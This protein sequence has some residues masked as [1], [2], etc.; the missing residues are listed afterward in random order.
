MKIEFV[1]RNYIP[2][3]RQY[4]SYMSTRPDEFEMVF[5]VVKSNLKRF[6]GIYR[7]FGGLPAV[8]PVVSLAQKVFFKE[9]ARSDADVFFYVGMLPSKAPDRP[10]VIDIEHIYSLMNFSSA[11]EEQKEVILRCIQNSFCKGVVPWS[12]AARLGMERFLGGDY[13]TV[14]DKVKVLYPAIPSLPLQSQ[15]DPR[16]PLQERVSVSPRFRF[17][18]IGKDANRKGLRQLLEA[19]DRLFLKNKDIVLNVVT[20]CPRDLQEKY[21]GHKAVNFYKPKFSPDKIMSEFFQKSDV[22]VMPTMADTFGL[23]FLEA[24]ASGLPVITT[25]QFANP[26]IVEQGRDG[27]LLKHEPLFLDTDLLPTSRLDEE[28]IL[29]PQRN[30]DLVEQLL[31]IMEQ[32]TSHPEQAREMGESASKKF[33][34]E[35]RFS[36]KKRDDLLAKILL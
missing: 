4:F 26:E 15:R 10:F 34:D 20:E 13:A 24:M 27:W 30:A 31:V 35:G 11:K 16:E 7:R 29:P 36:V 25:S 33:L 8:R 1:Y 32:C 28:Y 19:F 12:E 21:A 18:F 17:L 5:P 9:P 14:R 22:F 6:Y 3:Y 2:L 23:V